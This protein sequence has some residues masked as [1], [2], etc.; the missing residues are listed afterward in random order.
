MFH[1]KSNWS[2]QDIDQGE[3]ASGSDA[4]EPVAGI[5]AVDNGKIHHVRGLEG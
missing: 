5:E 2:K 1:S 3:E 4:M